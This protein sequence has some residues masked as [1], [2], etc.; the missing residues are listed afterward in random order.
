[1]LSML[2]SETTKA[3]QAAEA[4]VVA[5]EPLDTVLATHLI[6]PRPA[7]AGRY[8]LIGEGLF[9]DSSCAMYYV[10]R[11]VGE[12]GSGIV[13]Q[14][15]Y[16]PTC[17]GD[18]T[19]HMQ[20]TVHCASIVDVALVCRWDGAQYDCQGCLMWT[21]AVEKVAPSLFR[22]LLARGN[23]T[24]L[25]RVYVQDFDRQTLG[26]IFSMAGYAAAFKR[27]GLEPVRADHLQYYKVTVEQLE[28]VHEYLESLTEPVHGAGE[29]VDPD[30]EVNF[31]MRQPKESLPP[32]LQAALD[33]R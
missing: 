6:V 16:T 14:C 22:E 30:W 2:S 27:D 26:N 32:C 28:Q 12:P 24:T 25:S 19:P 3:F 9:S 20:Y 10:V 29:R 15:W 18:Y 5:G 23:P 13:V 8:D 33:S 17:G 7:E 11:D 1:M 31:V 4:A 21:E